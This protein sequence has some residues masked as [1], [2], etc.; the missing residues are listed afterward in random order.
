MR[1]VRARRGAGLGG[2]SDGGNWDPECRGADRSRVRGGAIVTVS[3][4]SVITVCRNSES[5]IASA[6]ASLRAQTFAD[7]EWIVIDGGSTDRTLDVVKA[8]GEPL[9][10]WV[11]EPDAGIYDAMNKGIGR[12]RGEILYFLNSD[13]SF[14]DPTV[15]ADA[16]SCFAADPALDLLFGDVVYTSPSRR[17]LRTYAHIDETTLLAE[18]LCHQAVFA[19]RRLFERIGAFNTAFRWNADYDWLIRAFRAQCRWR[20]VQRRIANFRLGGAHVQQ[21]SKLVQE[22]RT[23]RLQYVSFARLAWQEARQRLAR[24]WSRHLGGRPRGQVVLEE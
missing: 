14:Y 24:R 3:R 22:R 10:D 17:L 2:G 19:H 12:A 23:V 16:A 20:Y 18:D 11:S 7:R 5:V 15:L 9:G 8:S 13:D 4:F 1:R 21:L 6:I